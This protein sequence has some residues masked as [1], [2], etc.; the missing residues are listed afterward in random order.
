M[1]ITKFINNIV[2]N[3]FSNSK[4][5]RPPF[6]PPTTVNTPLPPSTPCNRQRAN[7]PSQQP[8]SLLPTSNQPPPTDNRPLPTDH[9]Q[10]T[11]ANQPVN[12]PTIIQLTNTHQPTNR[13]T[14]PATP[15]IA[16]NVTKKEERQKKKGKERRKKRKEDIS[17]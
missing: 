16:A 7:V 1:L 11:T 3:K 5:R 15:P 8:Q 12:R 9:C 2:N 4:R 13:P 17:K 14:K 6:N 10:P